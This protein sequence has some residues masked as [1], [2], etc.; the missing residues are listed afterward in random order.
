LIYWDSS[1]LVKKY[2]QENGSSLVLDWLKNDQQIITSQLTF[3]EIHATFAR[4]KREAAFTPGASE[5]LTDLFAK[6]W[7]AMVVVKMDDFL[8]EKIKALVDRY[9]LKG[10]DAVHLASALFVAE[11]AKIRKLAFACSD[12]QLL[13]AAGDEG[14]YIRNPLVG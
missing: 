6:D 4:K 8:L 2:L 1:A 9:P 11:K 5:A 3:A 12:I 7:K 10:A 14:L 13:K